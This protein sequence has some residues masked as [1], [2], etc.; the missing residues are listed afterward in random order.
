MMTFRRPS[1]DPHADTVLLEARASRARL[2]FV[3]VYSCADEFEA[4]MIRTR[5]AAGA[6]AL[7][8]RERI[9]LAALAAAVL[10][11]LWLV[12]PV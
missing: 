10:L 12:L 5:R 9:G 8:R 1:H 4:D 7:P 2:A 6:F 3:C 11:G